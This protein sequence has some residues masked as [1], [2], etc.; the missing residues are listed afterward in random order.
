[1]RRSFSFALRHGNALFYLPPKF[2]SYTEITLLPQL[3]VLPEAMCEVPDSIFDSTWQSV[4]IAPT[5]CLI[6]GQTSNF[7]SR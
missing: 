3:M 7:L 1:M 6:S 2:W 4:R 5:Q